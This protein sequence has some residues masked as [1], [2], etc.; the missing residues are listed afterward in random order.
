M[1]EWPDS[2]NKFI[3]APSVVLISTASISARGTITSSTLTSRKRRILLSIARSAGEKA[4]S[5]EALSASASAMSS[6]RL[7]PLRWRKKLVSRSNSVGRSEPGCCWLAF[8]CWMVLGPSADW[9]D[10]FESPP[11][12]GPGAV[13]V[14]SFITV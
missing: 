12:S 8:A 14:F 10:A 7:E 1:R 4:A 9:P 3:K 13:G 5:S 6:R 2:S 11:A